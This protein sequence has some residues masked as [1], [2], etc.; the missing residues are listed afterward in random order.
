MT[1]KIDYT[2][3]QLN[4][5]VG[6]QYYT[7]WDDSA[8]SLHHVGNKQAVVGGTEY[9]FTCDN[10]TYHD[11]NGPTTESM[12]LWDSVNNKMQWLDEGDSPVYVARV[13]LTFD[14]TI[15]SAGIMEFRI[16]PDNVAPDFTNIINVTY[17]SSETD[18]EALF[19]FYVK[20]QTKTDGVKIYYTPEGSGEVWNRGLLIYRT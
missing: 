18:M 13:K 5:V 1:Q 11:A 4:R 3:E 9:E 17:K 14:P 15:G 6:T 8:D 16:E 19:T 10:L 7:P 20:G 12:E 2:V